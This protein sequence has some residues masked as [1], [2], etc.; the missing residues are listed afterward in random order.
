MRYLMVL[1]AATILGVTAVIHSEGQAGGF[2][3]KITLTDFFMIQRG[4]MMLPDDHAKETLA[5]IRAQIKAQT[6]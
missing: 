3:L 1:V 2:A 4:L 6:Q 5:S